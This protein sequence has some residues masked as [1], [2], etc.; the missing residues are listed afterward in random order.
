MRLSVAAAIAIT[1]VT[2]A[3]NP[4]CAAGGLKR[5]CACA[6]RSIDYAVR[7]YV[8]PANITPVHYRDSVITRHY[9][10][11][12]TTTDAILRA[13]EPTN[14]ADFSGRH[15]FRVDASWTRS[16]IAGAIDRTITLYAH[17][18]FC[19]PARYYVG[20]QYLLHVGFVGD[21]V[22]SLIPCGS[23]HPTDSSATQAAIALLDSSFK[24]R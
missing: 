20:R 19:T 24:R 5:Q 2:P 21:T 9:F 18:D 15:Q 22:V 1:A 8:G 11:L 17:H 3:S 4:L 10:V 16:S 7:G 6:S 12:A 14:P 13:D 23:V